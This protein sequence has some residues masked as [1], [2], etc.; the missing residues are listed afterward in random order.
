[1]L[2]KEATPNERK[3]GL[4][5]WDITCFN[6]MQRYWG[7]SRPNYAPVMFEYEPSGRKIPP[8]KVGN[9]YYRGLLVI[10]Y[11]LEPVR[12]FRQI[13]LVLSS[14]IGGAFLE[15]A[16]RIRSDM[17]YRDIRARVSVS[18]S[19]SSELTILTEIF[20]TTNH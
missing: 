7:E 4:G 3:R 5:N 12:D 9:L 16:L 17:G 10:D 11:W 8:P 1:M 19:K 14:L 6:N 13:P 2:M 15:P 20:Q 18:P